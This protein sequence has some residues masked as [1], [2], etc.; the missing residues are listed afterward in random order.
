M[1]RFNLGQVLATPGALEALDKSHQ[2]PREFI[3]QH[4]AGKWGM[5]CPEDAAANDRALADGTRLLSAYVLKDG[6]KIWI[7]TE[8][9]NDYGIR[10]ATTLLLPDEY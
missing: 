8:A 10:T 5:V 1:K 6:T 2:S 7:I 3:A 4:A 9:E